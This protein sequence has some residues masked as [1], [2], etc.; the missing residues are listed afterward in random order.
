MNLY[1][2]IALIVI[3]WLSGFIVRG[4]RT[5]GTLRIDHRREGRYIYQFELDGDCDFMKRR[6]IVLNVDHNA[7]LESR[8]QQGL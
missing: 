7:V 3:A 4:I 8:K 5:D 2:A 6:R 1:L